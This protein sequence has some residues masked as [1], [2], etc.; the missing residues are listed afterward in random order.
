[1]TMQTYIV[2]LKDGVD[3]NSFWTEIEDP[4]TGLEYIPDRPVTIV[5]NRTLFLRL[6]EYALT[7]L[8]ADKLRSD[9]RVLAV[10]RPVRDLPNVNI[11]STAVQNPSVYDGNFNK[12]SGNVYLNPNNYSGAQANSINWGLIAHSSTTN[13]YGINISGN[14]GLATSLVYNY[15]ADGTGVDVL[16]NDSGLQID[17]P[18]FTNATGNTRV[19]LVDWN[20]IAVA[21]GANTSI[22]WNTVSYTDTD[23]HG[24]N[25]AGIA[26]GK[27]YGW[28]KNSNIFSLAVTSDPNIDVLDMFAM[29]L[30]W[31][32][33]KGNNNPTLVNMSW[34]L[35]IGIGVI[36]TD[37]YAQITGGNYQ[38]N[39]ILSGQ[40]NSYYSSRGLIPLFGD[41]IN[42]QFPGIP[43]DSPAINAALGTLIDAGIIVV[44]AAGNNSFKI[45]I[46]SN[47]SPVGDY[48][49]YIV[50]PSV[51]PGNLYYNRGFSPRDSRVIVVGALDTLTSSSGQTQKV[52][53]SCA[54]PG[55]DIWAAGTY[56]M[57]SGSNTTALTNAPYFLNT[58]YKQYKLSGT[59]QAS[60][61]VTGICALYLQANPTATMSQVKSWVLNNAGTD[62]F[63]TGN[64]TSYTNYLSLLGGNAKVVYNT[65]NTANNFVI[66][67]GIT[68][69]NI[70]L[71]NT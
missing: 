26:V 38:G 35:I 16:I 60:P 37:Y 41:G 13:P 11:V 45:D 48:D 59:S 47:P 58:S 50:A 24:T 63:E 62:L 14:T 32:Q 55:V 29:L 68:L 64:S 15:S 69:S 18:E 7:E 27:T 56:I 28:D 6:C 3:Y 49:N 23:G 54:G 8:E 36:G 30:Y 21:V 17:H 2:T 39:A 33:N 10:E 5:H 61:Q 19:Q 1:M 71:V 46:P 12:Q 9:P 25:V 51:A 52:Q 70:T 31:H 34:G 4:T 44:Q 22:D 20:D 42:L 66:S 43:Y 65:F 67:N 40:S 53:F 57:S